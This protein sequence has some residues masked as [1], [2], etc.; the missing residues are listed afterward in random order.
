MIINS[1]I[2]LTGLSSKGGSNIISFLE[3]G[4]WGKELVKIFQKVRTYLQLS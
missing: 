2:F 1:F 3:L 4:N